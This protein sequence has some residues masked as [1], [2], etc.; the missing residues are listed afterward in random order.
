MFPLALGLLVSSTEVYSPA[1]TTHQLTM[2]KGAVCS[3]GMVCSQHSPQNSSATRDSGCWI[4]LWP[5]REMPLAHFALQM[6][7]VAGW[8]RAAP[9]CLPELLDLPGHLSPPVVFLLSLMPSSYCGCSQ[10]HRNQRI[11]W[12]GVLGGFWPALDTAKPP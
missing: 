5:C 9:D 6:D 12:M 3:V 11:L 10:N 2:V 1:S 8:P 4:Q 7:L